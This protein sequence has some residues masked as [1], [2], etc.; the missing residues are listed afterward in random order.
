[1]K[2]CIVAG[3]LALSLLVPGVAF[4]A[5]TETQINAVLGLLRSFNA[6]A[7]ALY[8]VEASLRGEVLG[9]AVAC[10][11]LTMP[12]QR[13]MSDA[14]TDG[15]VAKLQKF[16]TTYYG[17]SEQD[18]VTGFFGSVTQRNVIRFQTEQGLSPVGVVGVLTRA[19][20][21]SVC[22]GG[23]V[24]T[25]PQVLK[26]DPICPA[27][28]FIPVECAIG[29]PSPRYDANGCQ[30]G[31]QCTATSTTAMLNV[32]LDASSPAY[33]LVAAG[34]KDVPLAAYRFTATGQSVTLQKVRLALASGPTPQAV[35]AD[36]EK[37][38][39]WNGTTKVGEGSFLGN[40]YGTVIT[41]TQ[42]VFIQAGTSLVLT[43][44]GDIA[45]I[46]IAEPVSVSGHLVQV[47]VDT[48][49]SDTTGQSLTGT[50]VIAAGV[51]GF[52]AGVRIMKSFPIVSS[53]NALLSP[54]GLLDGRLFRFKVSAD[55]RGPVSLGRY[56]ATL[57]ISGVSVTNVKLHA[58]S[59]SNYS[60]PNSGTASDGSI[61]T[62]GALGNIFLQPV[63]IPAG[64][65]R[66][67][68]LRGQVSGSGSV[69]TTVR[70]DTSPS[71]TGS[72]AMQTDTGYFIWSPNSTTTSTFATN[73][74]T[75][76]YGVP[77]LPGTG[78]TYTRTS[79]V[80]PPAAA[81]TTVTLSGPQSGSVITVGNPIPISWSYAN[82]PQ[83]SQVVLTVKNIQPSNPPSGMV[84]SGSWENIVSTPG[85]GTGSRNW[86]T[87]PTGLDYTGLYELTA[88]LRQCSSL[89][90]G[91][92][93]T[94]GAVYAQSNAIQ[95][96]L[97]PSTLQPPV[98]PVVAP[99][100]TAFSASPTSITPG[101]STVLSWSSTGTT[102]GGCYI[103]AGTGSSGPSITPSSL[104]I[105]S[106]S[107]TVAPSVTTAY[108]LWCTNSS[109]DGSQYA[110]KTVTVTVQ[111]PTV[112]QPVA[113][114][115][116]I[117]TPVLCT[118]TTLPK[119]DANGCLTGLMCQEK[120]VTE[121]IFVPGSEN[122]PFQQ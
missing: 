77:G 63:Q 113:C 27:I 71:G 21:A 29:A 121:R 19:K 103:F 62:Y 104:W 64:A 72:F 86:N 32:S 28:A 93:N 17:L 79:S 47:G 89:G 118:G 45:L 38:T 44:K 83:N 68:E 97:L 43:I 107:F 95:F 18:S 55:S 57:G 73:D 111:T 31:W 39:L 48:G 92:T 105:G 94:A 85:S 30:T 33:A 25:T 87:G 36:L 74:W 50:T 40:S 102:N 91:H 120:P 96:T 84:S 52:P 76:G 2:K 112:P 61:P 78:L 56:Y 35:P 53:D 22:S 5:R 110:E 99:T 54:T 37:V 15:Q 4:A 98:P 11:V 58:Y 42:S 81:A 109:K 90:C 26:P 67:F 16:L 8:D 12:L 80:M 88:Q 13:G 70:G 101:Q 49:F 115:L 9:A 10:P 60:I 6:D 24:S 41:L 82:A 23:S 116:V 46:G 1:M 75:N 106:G 59:D 65:T 66:Y 34:T 119:Y 7:S 114:P 51:P 100:I 3:V 108:R 14:T 20:I 122:S 69:S 117:Y